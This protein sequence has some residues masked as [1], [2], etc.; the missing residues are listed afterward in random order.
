MIEGRLASARLHSMM[1]TMMFTSGYFGK[2]V[3]WLGIDML[4]QLV[5]RF[6][7]STDHVRNYDRVLGASDAAVKQ[8]LKHPSLA[9]VKEADALVL[10]LE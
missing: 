10:V 8:A 2:C 3:R 6:P 4:D 1:M 7:H 5:M 9:P